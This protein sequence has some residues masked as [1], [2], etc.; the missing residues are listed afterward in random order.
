VLERI[1][2]AGLDIDEGMV[3]FVGD[4]LYYGADAIHMLALLGTRSGFF[5][6]LTYHCFRS[7]R[8]SKILYP[9]LKAARN[10]L[11]KVLRRRRINNLR[12]AGNDRF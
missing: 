7:R 10:L 8:I 5:N 4:E 12:V 1:S 6:R 3:L 2:A 9:L 11:L